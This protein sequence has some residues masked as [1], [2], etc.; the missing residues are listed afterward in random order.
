MRIY[1]SVFWLL[2][3]FTTVQAQTGPARVLPGETALSSNGYSV[4]LV[5]ALS[6][7]VPYRV[8]TLDNPRRLVLDFSDID[9]T[10]MPS[11]MAD[12]VVQVSD[13]RFGYFKPEQSR[14]ILDL[15]EPF[16]IET[17]VFDDHLLTVTL[18]RASNAEFS[19]QANPPIDGLLARNQTA[20]IIQ[21]D[22]GL[23]LVVLDAGHGG[24]DPGAIRNE[25]AEKKV[26]LL[27]ALQLRDALLETRRFRVLMTRED[28][29]YLELPER[30]RLARA[31]QA[32]IFISLHANTVEQGVARGTTV[33]SL[34]DEASNDEAAN[35]AE[36]ENRSDIVAG[37]VLLG[38]EDEIANI[39]IDMAQRETN[40]ASV[41]FADILGATLRYAL[42]DN[43]PSRRMA[44]G[45]RV[46]R[47]VDTPSVLVELGF[48][49]NTTDL[50]NLMSQSWRHEANLAIIAA[51]DEWLILAE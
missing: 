36:F 5:L 41:G 38:Q 18:A 42:D 39:L 51:L 7:A 33:Y 9:F 30:I 28:D 12:N 17:A 26:T 46:L 31:S 13:L 29:S 6:R 1:I 43:A 2:L 45:F 37:A 34:S 32:D 11:G 3:S 22:A 23:P 24:I 47:A 14:L 16:T 20:A 49:S 27:F 8:F 48:M 15:S 40:A 19:Q 25:V 44:A 10:F 35:R 50:A 4:T 21:G